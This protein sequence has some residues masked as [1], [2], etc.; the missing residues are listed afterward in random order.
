MKTTPLSV[1]LCCFVFANITSVSSLLAMCVVCMCV[2]L[3]PLLYKGLLQRNYGC[4]HVH[5]MD[6]VFCMRD[7][8]LGSLGP[9]TVTL[10]AC[11]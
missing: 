7:V 2:R 1:L 5:Y 4:T 6:T 9:S 8:R 3:V 10:I 11:M